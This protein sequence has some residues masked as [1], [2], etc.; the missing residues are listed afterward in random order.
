LGPAALSGE[1]GGIPK[2]S[3]VPHLQRGRALWPT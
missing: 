3:G 2:D 1:D